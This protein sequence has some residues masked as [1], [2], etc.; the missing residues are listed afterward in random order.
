MKV[1]IDRPSGPAPCDCPDGPCA[2]THWAYTGEPTRYYLEVEITKEE[3]ERIQ[4][5]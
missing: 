2:W 5:R 4:S 1:K 3:A